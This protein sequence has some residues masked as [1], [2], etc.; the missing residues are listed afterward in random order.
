M[1]QDNI[2]VVAPIPTSPEGQAMQ[3]NYTPGSFDGQQVGNNQETGCFV[4]MF[5]GNNIA[6][7]LANQ[8]AIFASFKNALKRRSIVPGDSIWNTRDTGGVW[9]PDA[10]VFPQLNFG[11]GVSVVAATTALIG[12]L[13]SVSTSMDGVTLAQDQE[14][15][16]KNGAIPSKYTAAVAVATANVDLSVTL[17]GV[18]V[19]GVLLANTNRV[20]L[21]GQTDPTENG[22][23]AVVTSP[24]LA[25][26]TTDMDAT[27]E[28]VFG[29][30]ITISGG[31]V[32]T[33]AIFV[34]S[35]KPAVLDTD[36]IH[37]AD[38]T[39]IAG[40]AVTHAFDGTYVVGVVGGGLAPLTRSTD[41]NTA[42]KISGA[43]VGV[44]SGTNN[45]GYSFGDLNVIT[46]LG[47]DP[48]NFVNI[49]T[50]FPSTLTLDNDKGAANSDAQV[51]RQL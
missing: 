26:R 6:G 10:N 4:S 43:V 44:Q 7:Q 29:K 17:D 20:L 28:V 11:F 39:T 40:E 9:S 42:A 33:N 14:V 24:A 8:A 51:W 38:V 34:V 13:T 12:N 18:T 36:P 41:G 47:V 45:G 2:A 27:N 50:L 25:A 37:F 5:P 15:L 22:L 30:G 35:E 16:V 19:D 46:T 3:I 31:T 49:N 48:F 32:Y 1:R 23:Y 21:A